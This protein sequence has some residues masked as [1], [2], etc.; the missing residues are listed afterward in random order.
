MVQ[1]GEAVAVCGDGKL[2]LL[3]AQVLAIS[4]HNV[5]FFGRHERKMALVEGVKR[6][7]V[8]EGPLPAEYGGV[9]FSRGFYFNY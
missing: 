2:G 5:T 4:G 1:P 6:V 8:T 3:I 9:G 7:V